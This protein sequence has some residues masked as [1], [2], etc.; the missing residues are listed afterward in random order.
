MINIAIVIV[1]HSQ[2]KTYENIFSTQEVLKKSSKLY[3]D[4][5]W[6]GE[7]SSQIS[8]SVPVFFKQKGRDVSNVH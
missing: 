3:E 4:N 8:L 7:V 5:G 6:K 1:H 2:A